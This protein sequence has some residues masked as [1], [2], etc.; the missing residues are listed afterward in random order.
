MHIPYSEY[1]RT[2][3]L[4]III[5]QFVFMVIVATL[6]LALIKKYWQ[7]RADIVVSL[8][9]FF[10]FLEISTITAWI[11]KYMNYAEIYN[12]I[13]FGV[14]LG[15]GLRIWWTNF[16]YVFNSISTI[17]LILFTQ[18]LF[19]FSSRKILIYQLLMV[20][21]FNV[22]NIY[23]GIYVY[24]PGGSSLT[25]PMSFLLIVVMIVPSVY[26]FKYTRRDVARLSPS[27]F[28]FGFQLIYW[29]TSLSI[30]AYLYW[31]LSIAFRFPEWASAL[32]WILN[33]F[34]MILIS[35]GFTLPKWLR[36]WL[37][38]TRKLKED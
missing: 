34:V 21:A 25:A 4:I 3:L 24:V 36:L 33:S 22:W 20:I 6:I 1:P 19:K 11:P 13:I 2:D 26:L 10:V 23:H 27:I 7:N 15:G 12:D 35:L 30:I 16:S 17:F 5:T 14:P 28:R 29:G 31:I 37:K 9:L 18:Q 38:N 32:S 8:L